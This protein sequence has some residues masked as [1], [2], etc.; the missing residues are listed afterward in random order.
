M[1]LTILTFNITLSS[2]LLL[3]FN[4]VNSMSIFKGQVRTKLQQKFQVFVI[5]QQ[6]S[7]DAWVLLT[8]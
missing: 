7:K 8:K 6:L 5:A 2:I 1:S 3:T 4:F